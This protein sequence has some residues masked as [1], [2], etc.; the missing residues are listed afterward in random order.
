MMKIYLYAHI[1]HHGTETT[2][3]LSIYLSIYSYCSNLEH[4]A[5][6]KRFVSF[7]FLNVRQ[8]VGLLGREVSPTQDRN[9]HRKTQTQNKLR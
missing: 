7:Q 8:S 4:R 9:L 6:M 1:R 2:I 5:S 3:H